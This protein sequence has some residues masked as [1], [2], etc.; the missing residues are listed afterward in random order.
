MV[1]ILYE[2]NHLLILNKPAGLPTQSPPQGGDSLESAA[3]A[4]IKERDEKKGGVY[5]HAIHRLDTPVS[6]IVVFA[7]TSKALGRLQEMMRS[8]EMEKI[9]EGW[10]E[11]DIEKEEGSLTHYLIHGDKKALLGKA[12]D[13]LAKLS[14]LHFKTLEKKAGLTRLRIVLETGRYH[15]IRAQWAFSGHPIWGDKK[16]GS[17]R[18]YSEAGIALRAVECSFPH[19]VKKELIHIKLSSG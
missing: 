18:A 8:K 13:P 16:Y 12:Q 11:G 10:V 9:Y 15:Q 17:T 6:G 2:D 3:K 4:M 14:K 19:P 1:E 7:K 5:L